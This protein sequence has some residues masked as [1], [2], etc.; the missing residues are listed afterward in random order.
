MADPVEEYLESI[1]SERTN[2]VQTRQPRSRSSENSIS[3]EEIDK[4]LE[5]MEERIRQDGIHRGMQDSLVEPLTEYDYANPAILSPY[6]RRLMELAMGRWSALFQHSCRRLF[7]SAIYDVVFEPIR[8]FKQEWFEKHIMKYDYIVFLKTEAG[9]GEAA[10]LI[11]EAVMRQIFI[12]AM[13]GSCFNQDNDSYFLL[14]EINMAIVRD[15]F[16][17]VVTD[18]E[19]ALYGL[20][21]EIRDGI[22]IDQINSQSCTF[23]S[24][25]PALHIPFMMKFGFYDFQM[26]L[27]LSQAFLE[28]WKQS[29][30]FPEPVRRPDRKHERILPVPVP[31]VAGSLDLVPGCRIILPVRPGDRRH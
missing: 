21:C 7:K 29:N 6:Q 27:L 28:N 3:Q 10:L 9:S 14:T 18:L 22:I 13:K 15:F 1:R 30:R 26:E 23:F 8:I 31:V 5:I 11:R 24:D 2:D 25:Y 17:V 19:R 16:T 4:L 12:N 20:D